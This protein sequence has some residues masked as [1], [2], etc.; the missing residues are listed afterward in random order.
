MSG[1]RKSAKLVRAPFL[2]PSWI[3]PF[4]DNDT[5]NPG[6]GTAPR[7]KDIE[8]PVT[9]GKQQQDPVNGNDEPPPSSPPPSANEAKPSSRDEIAIALSTPRPQIKKRYTTQHQPGWVLGDEAGGYTTSTRP[10]T[11]TR[12]ATDACKANDARPIAHS[13]VF[14]KRPAS[15]RRGGDAPPIPPTTSH[16]YSPS[17]SPGQA[18]SAPNS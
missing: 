16:T 15:P 11:S 3:L 12:K 2:D 4:A 5:P 6:D 10:S 13:S 14:S 9:H 18:A 7:S 1:L 8:V 17:F